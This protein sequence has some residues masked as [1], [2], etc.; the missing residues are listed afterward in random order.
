M[1]NEEDE[2]DMVD[3]HSLS[4]GVTFSQVGEDD[5]TLW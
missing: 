5:M 2:N 4:R 1:V 3:N